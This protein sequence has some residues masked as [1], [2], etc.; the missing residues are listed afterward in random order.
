MGTRGL[1]FVRYRGR[2]FVYYNHWDSY[3]EGLGREL[4]DT[5]P[6]DPTQYQAWLEAYRA[7]FARLVHQYETQCLPVTIQS[8]AE[9]DSD[10]ALA[11]RYEKSYL[12]L[13]DR[14]ETPPLKFL[15]LDWQTYGGEWV[16]TLDLDREI[17]SIDH[18]VH[19]HLHKVSSEP[20]WIMYLGKDARRRRAPAKCTP[21]YL[22]ADPVFRPTVNDA[23]TAAFERLNVK[24]VR[25]ESFHVAQT[26]S[27]L[28]EAFLME[29]FRQ[30]H[31]EYRGLLDMSYLE[32]APTD[33][34]FREIAYAIL[35]LATG[36]VTFEDTHS[37]DANHQGEGYYLIPGAGAMH[38]NSPGS[39]PTVLP[40]FL[41]ER[42]DTGVEAGSAPR[43]TT[44][45]HDGVLVHLVT[46]LDRV[47]IEKAAIAEAVDAGLEHGRKSFYAIIFSILDV[48]LL[49]I[50]R[51]E[52]LTIFV[53]RSPKL[54]LFYFDDINSSFAQGPR[55]SPFKWPE[56]E[57]ELTLLMTRD[58]N[59]GVGHIEDVLPH[60]ERGRPEVA[61][62]NIGWAYVF[63]NIMHFFDAA[64][65]HSLGGAVSSILPNETLANV[66][67]L[68]DT[69]TYRILSK[70][71][72]YCHK[73]SLS[74]LRLNDRYTIVH[75]DAETPSMTLHDSRTGTRRTSQYKRSF[76]PDDTGLILT[77]II[78]TCDP[79]RRSVVDCVKW[80]FMDISEMDPEYPK[81]ITMPRRAHP[82]PHTFF[83]F[84]SAIDFEGLF[85][86]PDYLYLKSVQDGWERYAKKLIHTYQTQGDSYV[87]FDMGK[88]ECLQ[89]PGYREITTFRCSGVHCFLRHAR[90]ESA[91]EWER[92]VQYGLR[93]LHTRETSKD[94]YMSD[95]LAEK[96]SLPGRP[97]VIAFTTRVQLFYYVHHRGEKPAV[98]E[99]VGTHCAELAE[100]CTDPDPQH[101]LVPLIPGVIDLK[102][103]AARSEFEAWFRKFCSATGEVTEYYD[104][105]SD[106]QQLLVRI[107]EQPSE[108]K[109][110][111]TSTEPVGSDVVYELS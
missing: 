36:D 23:S 49:R 58:L 91:D 11:E 69:R 2:Y 12:A 33:F 53:E 103:D 31:A 41:W 15:P 43:Q 27:S 26:F 46:G 8:V 96:Y 44:Y 28:R 101:R 51:K 29:T 102:D 109:Q 60:L 70:L 86:L 7:T 93:R 105:F 62:T 39:A 37:F 77:L 20:N 68:S 84:N 100:R 66:M 48:I 104:P 108:T 3:P 17:F 59:D 35:S 47:G 87:T 67:Q 24:T 13:D 1:M 14:L 65:Y 98:P 52:D 22:L 90:E 76:Y 18:A 88:F 78:G 57:E 73:T 63:V 42:H 99:G 92:T 32:W 16:Y 30:I 74:E 106:Q 82:H 40:C 97:V 54:T 38:A 55:N 72:A 10:A 79:L 110:P 50:E 45:W 85:H 19:F 80:R 75:S 56:I 25:P 89:P 5:I 21:P 81:K 34:T 95:G 111:V 71:S 61:K 4:I 6:T 94:G 64:R 83:G 9:E 107:A